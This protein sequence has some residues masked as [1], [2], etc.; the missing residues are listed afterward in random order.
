[1]SQPERGR[2]VP[3]APASLRAHPGVA[4]PSVS[5]EAVEENSMQ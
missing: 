2:D 3:S 5:W 4:A 1:M